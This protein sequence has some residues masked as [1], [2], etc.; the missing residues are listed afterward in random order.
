MEE[1]NAGLKQS[2]SQLQSQQ[3]DLENRKRH[4]NLRI[5]GIPESVVYRE[6]CPYLLIIFNTIAPLIPDIDWRLD[7]AHRSLAPKPPVGT[8]PRD[9]I[10]RFHYDS[11]EALT[12]AT[13][14]KTQLEFKGAKILIFS[15]L[16]IGTQFS[17]R[18]LQESKAFI[19]NIGLP[20]LPEEDPVPLY[21]TPKPASNPGQIWTPVRQKSQK[22]FS[23]PQWY[24]FPRHPT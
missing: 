9:I 22:A 7:R 15:D 6:I 1:D 2:I 18:D 19:R 21:A 12:L 3:E 20:P 16:S 10:V 4:Q 14:N 8:N 17:M 24:L 5:R 11:K 13:H 23:T